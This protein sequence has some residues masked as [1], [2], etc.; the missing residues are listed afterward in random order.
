MKRQ[1]VTILLILLTSPLLFAQEG[2]DG[3][4]PYVERFK[5]VMIDLSKEMIQVAESVKTVADA[6][7]AELKVE[8]AMTGI[9]D[10]FTELA[11]NI[12]NMTLREL[13]GLQQMQ[14][15]SED[16]EVKKWMNQAEAAMDKQK[17][18]YPEAAEKL[19]EIGEK[20]SEKMIKVMMGAMMKIDQKLGMNELAEGGFSTNVDEIETPEVEFVEEYKRTLDSVTDNLIKE[21]YLIRNVQDVVDAEQRLKEQMSVLTSAL[22]ELVERWDALS[23]DEREEMGGVLTILED[24]EIVA[25][26]ELL[27][28]AVQDLA[29]RDVEGEYYFREMMKKYSTTYEELMDY[30]M[31]E[32]YE[33]DQY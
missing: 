4:L 27:E 3:S 17:R 10:L 18:D 24:P 30:L 20:H 31:D 28:D 13:K 11:E 9:S 14:N 7:R 33:T 22:S 5:Q 16:P 2:D 19:K 23:A 25:R 26:L 6:E 12:D 32:A 8:K 1:S 29:M 21:I 15:I